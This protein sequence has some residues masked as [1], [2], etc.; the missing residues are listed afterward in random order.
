MR[1]SVNSFLLFYP[2]IDCV[3]TRGCASQIDHAQQSG[4]D[5]A[6]PDRD[7]PLPVRATD[8][9]DTLGLAKELLGREH[10]NRVR[11]LVSGDRIVRTI[12]TI[13]SV[14]GVPF[15]LTVIDEGSLYVPNP[16]MFAGT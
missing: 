4:K 9:V 10:S 16:P 14:S 12:F 3:S 13:F 15:L 7:H 2:H 11:I 6:W 8:W 1:G 5:Y